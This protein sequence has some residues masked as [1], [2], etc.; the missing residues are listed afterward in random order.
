MQSLELKEEGNQ[1][2]LSVSSPQGS[3]L[4]KG[5][6][7]LRKK[8][9][10]GG[11]YFLGKVTSSSI[12]WPYLESVHLFTHH[13]PIY[14]PPTLP[15]IHSSFLPPHHFIHPALCYIH[16]RPWGSKGAQELKSSRGYRFWTQPCG[17]CQCVPS[18][19]NEEFCLGRNVGE[20]LP[21]MRGHSACKEGKDPAICAAGPAGARPGRQRGRETPSPQHKY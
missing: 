21:K 17:K 8:S 20:D 18:G 4:M 14:P 5:S 2:E 15:S 19:E 11:T 7:T 6:R 16:A 3:Q 12:P 1:E 13:L 9:C 10:S